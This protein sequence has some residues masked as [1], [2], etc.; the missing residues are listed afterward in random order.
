MLADDPTTTTNK[1]RHAQVLRAKGLVDVALLANG[2]AVQ[3]LMI[4]YPSQSTKKHSYNMARFVRRC[5]SIVSLPA[6]LAP[7]DRWSL[8]A[9]A[10][11]RVVCLFFC[12]LYYVGTAISGFLSRVRNGGRKVGGN[13]VSHCPSHLFD[14]RVV[15]FMVDFWTPSE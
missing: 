4:T 15:T 5:S 13:H 9:W 1:T 6:L 8:T 11:W 3:D 2:K 10:G 7:A 12:S 14:M